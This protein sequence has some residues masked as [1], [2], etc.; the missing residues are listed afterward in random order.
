MKDMI[1]TQG[2]PQ[3]RDI[4]VNQASI[5]PGF[6]SKH[7]TSLFKAIEG[8]S[9]ALTKENAFLL[10]FRAIAYE[11]F[12]KEAQLRSTEIQRESDRGHPFWKQAIVQSHLATFRAGIEIGMRDID[13][14]NGLFDA[15]FISGMRDDFHFAAFRF[16][17]V[18]PI[19]ACAAF[20]PEFDMDGKRLQKLGRDAS[21]F[22]HMSLTVTVFA[23]QTI[24]VFGWTGA[25]DG[26]SRALA[27]SFT[28]VDDVQ[29]ADALVRLLFAQTDNL[30]LRPSWWRALPDSTKRTLSA[31][32]LSGTTLQPRSG[33]QLASG[34][35]ILSGVTVAEAAS[36]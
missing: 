27:D 29:K 5:F 34:P 14:W 24:A 11:R 6:C 32:V 7:D 18:L 12:A 23:G 20:H 17:Q 19:V 4:G 36:G 25:D 13:R 15:R 26:A 2:R 8:K 28:R 1:E 3:P 35:I 30:F 33:A 22:E 16:D 9:L 21:D 10:A 31:M